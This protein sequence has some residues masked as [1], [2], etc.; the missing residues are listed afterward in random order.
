MEVRI[1]DEVA[2][3]SWSGRNANERLQRVYDVLRRRP[4]T[5]GSEQAEKL[6]VAIHDAAVAVPSWSGRNPIAQGA[7]CNASDGRRPLIV[8]SERGSHEVCRQV[9]SRV[10][11]PSWSGRNTIVGVYPDLRAEWSPSPHGRVGTGGDAWHGKD[12]TD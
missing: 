12:G 11:V 5:V 3:P 9:H 4:L 8:G 7:Q 2:V 10:A 6:P 1:V